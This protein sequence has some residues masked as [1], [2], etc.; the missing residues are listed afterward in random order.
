[1]WAIKRFRLGGSDYLMWIA[2][3]VAIVWKTLSELQRKV[4]IVCIALTGAW[5]IINQFIEKIY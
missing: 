3:A 2:P 4:L 1:V 5:L